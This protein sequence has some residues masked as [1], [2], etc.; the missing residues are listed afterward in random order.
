MEKS[1]KPSEPGRKPVPPIVDHFTRLFNQIKRD[2]LLAKGLC[3]ECGQDTLEPN[4]CSSCKIC[5]NCG[6][7]SCD[8]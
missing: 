8:L 5:R 3:P 6:W 4:G 7:S 2:E 1:T